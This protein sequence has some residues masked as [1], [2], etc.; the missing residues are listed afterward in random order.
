MQWYIMY[1]I[2]HLKP[3]T[4]IHMQQLRVY[5]TKV[6][7]RSLTQTTVLRDVRKKQKLCANSVVTWNLIFYPWCM[8]QDISRHKR[9]GMYHNFCMVHIFVYFVCG[10]C[11]RKFWTFEIF[12][13]LKIVHEPWPALHTVNN[14][15]RLIE[16]LTHKSASIISLSLPVHDVQYCLMIFDELLLSLFNEVQGCGLAAIPYKIKTYKNLF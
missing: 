12:A 6:S 5:P 3:L 2:L 9:V 16:R 1:L 14:L 13:M 11:V 7:N 4:F 8:L 15:S 10:C